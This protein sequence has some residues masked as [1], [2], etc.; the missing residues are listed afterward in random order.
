MV[1]LLDNS[2]VIKELPENVKCERLMMSRQY[3]LIYHAPP[4]KP[5][6]LRHLSFDL[7]AKWTRNPYRVLAFVARYEMRVRG[8]S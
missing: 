8:L 7:V 6:M 1:T 5:I 3:R 4:E 2:K